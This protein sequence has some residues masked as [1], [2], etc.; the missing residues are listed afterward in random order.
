MPV[1]AQHGRSAQ[2][3]RAWGVVLRSTPRLLAL[4]LAAALIAL[5]AYLAF[6]GPSPASDTRVPG[7]SLAPVVPPEVVRTAQAFG[8]RW[9]YHP[10]GTTSTEWVD[11]LRPL[12]LA[13]YWSTLETV[14]PQNIPATKVTRDPLVV[15]L[16]DQAIGGSA[17]VDV[18]TDGAILRLFLVRTG[19]GWL[20]SSYE[21]AG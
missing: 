20:V 21:Q 7:V 3:R 2:L 18:A 16:N 19:D 10:P 6:S 9:V 8:E 17:T 5:G 15:A 1:R 14:D 11:R 12:T 4:V 13:S